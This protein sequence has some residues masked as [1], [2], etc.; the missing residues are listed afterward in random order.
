MEVGGPAHLGGHHQQHA[1][2]DQQGEGLVVG[3]VLAVAAHG[4]PCGGPGDEEEQQGAA[5]AVQHDAQEEA[6]V[7]V[8]VAL[9]RPVERRAPQT[10]GGAHVLSGRGGEVGG[11]GGG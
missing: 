9:S 1:G 11:E 5:A 4:A 6:L 3:G 10:P 2:L 8:Q 7:E